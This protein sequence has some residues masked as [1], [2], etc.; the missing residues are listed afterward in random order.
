MAVASYA[1]ITDA[2]LTV[3]S[4]NIGSGEAQHEALINYVS[5]GIAVFS[6]RDL[7]NTQ[8]TEIRDGDGE[9]EMLLN[10][11]PILDSTDDSEISDPALYIDDDGD[12]VW[13]AA[14]SY[15]LTLK[16]N[17][18]KDKGILYFKY[19]STFP[20]GRRN[21]KVVY[22]AGYLNTAAVPGHMKLACADIVSV[23]KKK[24]DDNLHGTKSISIL[25]ETTTYD[26]D[27]WPPGALAVF[28]RDARIIV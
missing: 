2:E 26:Y 13:Q 23:V 14:S 6:H 4:P 21:I 1:L 27:Q 11:W 5:R 16:W 7:I 15:S 28:Q 3:L 25:S 20:R 12:D 9:I 18:T 19:N 8:H 24:Y 10:N 17:L 22:N